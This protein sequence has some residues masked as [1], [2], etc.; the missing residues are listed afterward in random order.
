MIEEVDRALHSNDEINKLLSD[1]VE[2][3]MIMHY[4]GYLDEENESDFAPGF[5][6]WCH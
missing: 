6:D 4:F 5:K 3:K 1:G 2:N